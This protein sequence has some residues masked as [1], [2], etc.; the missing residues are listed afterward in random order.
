MVRREM[1]SRSG[2]LGYKECEVPERILPLSSFVTL[3]KLVNFPR[4]VSSFESKNLISM[5][6]FCLDLMTNLGKRKKI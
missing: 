6:H 5:A 2:R 1:A 4:P 3:V